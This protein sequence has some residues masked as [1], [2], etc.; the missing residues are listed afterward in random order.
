M[1]ASPEPTVFGSGH[2]RAHP[3]PRGIMGALELSGY[4]LLVDIGG[5]GAGRLGPQAFLLIAADPDPAPRETDPPTVTH[6]TLHHRHLRDEQEAALFPQ[7]A[8]Q[9]A[10]LRLSGYRLA[11]RREGLRS[12][13]SVVDPAS[14]AIALEIPDKHPGRLGLGS[15]ATAARLL[16]A[17]RGLPPAGA[18][19]ALAGPELTRQV[20]LALALGDESV[21]GAQA[22]ELADRALELTR[23]DSGLDPPAALEQARRDSDHQP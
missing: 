10:Y 14:G 2:L 12:R 23:G 9:L 19:P 17:A 1:S 6:I 11:P 13:V 22:A 20:L 18:P 7:L 15:G 16:A 3:L 4:Q 8:A 21:S 5:V